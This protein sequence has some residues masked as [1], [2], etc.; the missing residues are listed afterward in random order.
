M[1]F[2]D[3]RQLQKSE[4]QEIDGHQWIVSARKKT[5]IPYRVRLMEQPIAIIR[6][7]ASEGREQI[8]DRCEYHT[9][10]K[11]LPI[12]LKECGITK[13]ISFHCARHTFAIMA[14]N[15][16]MPIESVSRILG[17]SNITTT[18]IYAKITMKKLDGDFLRME[19]GLTSFFST[20]DKKGIRAR[21]KNL[22]LSI[23][24]LLGRENVYVNKGKQ[25]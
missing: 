3:I 23:L 25:S 17:H 2:I 16:G 21:L 19:S 14:L 8:F 9:V 18:Q 12:I 11:R 15:N 22:I 20:N 7:Y 6:R 10:S 1:S 5:G 24:H 4:I 13:R